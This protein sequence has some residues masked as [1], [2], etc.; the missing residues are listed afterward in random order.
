MR[1]ANL[2]EFE[3]FLSEKS[4]HP[5]SQGI[6]RGR[7]DACTFIVGAKLPHTVVPGSQQASAFQSIAIG[8]LI[9]P[10]LNRLFDP[11]GIL[12]V[13]LLDSRAR[14]DDIRD[15]HVGSPNGL[16]V[17]VPEGPTGHERVAWHSRERYLVYS[18]DQCQGDY[19]QR[20][21]MSNF[22]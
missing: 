17:D 11:R 13:G 12:F 7:Q 4:L 14:N 5:R 8:F 22:G 1:H 19:Y 18:S 9:G 21:A 2:F 20:A 15:V 6:L 10:L 16:R 3:R